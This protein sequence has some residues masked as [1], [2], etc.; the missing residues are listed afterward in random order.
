MDHCQNPNSLGSEVIVSLW[1]GK[2]EWSKVVAGLVSLD[3]SPNKEQN[4]KL[5]P[6]VLY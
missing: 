3:V 2:T 1:T 5:V 6:I 4:I